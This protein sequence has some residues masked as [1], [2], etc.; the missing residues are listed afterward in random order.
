[1]G[2]EVSH[3]ATVTAFHMT[4]FKQMSLEG[5]FV[6]TLPPTSD[7]GMATA[8][9]PWPSHSSST[10]IPKHQRHQRPPPAP[11]PPMHPP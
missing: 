11:V 7:M 10:W 3:L 4:T 1:M 2:V 8:C 9:T 6:H 5:L